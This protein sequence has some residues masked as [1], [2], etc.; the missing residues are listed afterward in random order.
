MGSVE[1]LWDLWRVQMQ[2]SSLF[3][4][5][6]ITFLAVNRVLGIHHGQS[7]S[8]IFNILPLCYQIRN[9]GRFFRISVVR[10]SKDM[11]SPL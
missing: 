7:F 1:D 2:L 4:L 9:L 8:D 3:H 10:S 5:L 6:V 11:C